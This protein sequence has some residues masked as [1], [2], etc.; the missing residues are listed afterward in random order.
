MEKAVISGGNVG[1][2]K[3]GGGD[4]ESPHINAGSFRAD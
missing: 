3:G 4:V 2:S 1:G